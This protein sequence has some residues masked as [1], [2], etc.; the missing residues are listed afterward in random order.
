M[1][2]SAYKTLVF[3]CDGVILDSNQVKT[4]AFNRV[5]L[6]FGSE[7]ANELVSYHLQ[8]GGVSRYQKFE[9]F[10]VDVLKRTYDVE[11]IGDLVSQYALQVCERLLDC[12]ISPN[13]LDLRKVTPN[14]DW[15]VVSGGN[16][17]ELE[18]IFS[19]RKIAPLFNKGIFGSPST[20]DEIINREVASG[21]LKFPSL[22]IGDSRYDHE[23][24]KRAGMDFIFIHGWTEFSGWQEYCRVHQLVS[25]GSLSDLNAI[26]FQG[27]I[28]SEEI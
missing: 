28:I 14:T 24:A 26:I 3:D 27:A 12:P 2:Q 7:A 5:G 16:Q 15:M 19:E 8:H 18:Y 17:A 4:E 20:K 6:Q 22:F 11:K 25:L 23:V 10:W 9:Y 21:Q 13:L 1:I